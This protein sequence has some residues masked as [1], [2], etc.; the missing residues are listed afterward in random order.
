MGNL[1]KGAT[2]QNPQVIVSKTLVVRYSIK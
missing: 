1:F 2:Q